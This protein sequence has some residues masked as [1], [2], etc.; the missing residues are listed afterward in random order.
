[1]VRS[2]KCNFVNQSLQLHYPWFYRPLRVRTPRRVCM[3]PNKLKALIMRLKFTL[4]WRPIK[5]FRMCAHTGGVK[6][7]CG[8]YGEYVSS[9]SIIPSWSFQ[10][11]LRS[12][13]LT[14]AHVV[15][16]FSTYIQNSIPTSTSFQSVQ[17]I[18]H[19][20]RV[21][22][23]AV[24]IYYGGGQMREWLYKVLKIHWFLFPSGWAWARLA[25]LKDHSSLTL[26]RVHKI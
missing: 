4:N 15:L 17:L 2:V 3:Y 10:T 14:T 25:W 20:R 5:P 24:F 9:A 18:R 8:D 12:N 19:L 22:S 11:W 26:H 23:N 13:G 1:M 21:G 6:V 7:K 16:S